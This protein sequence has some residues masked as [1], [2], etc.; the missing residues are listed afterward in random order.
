[1]RLVAL[2]LLIFCGV[3]A[4]VMLLMGIMIAEQTRGA[5]RIVL[6]GCMVLALLVPFS[7]AWAFR[8]GGLAPVGLVVLHLLAV[9]ALYV[10]LGLLV[11]QAEPAPTPRPP[12]GDARVV[13]EYLAANRDIETLDLSN[14]GLV[15]VPPAVFVLP[16]LRELRLN[17]NNLVTVPD[18][19]LDMPALRVV[20]LRDN[21][22]PVEEMARIGRAAQQAL[23]SGRRAEPLALVQ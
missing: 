18:A 4:M 22:I 9:P 6:Y 19:L 8:A 5:A 1:M 17:R 2:P 23:A 21:P 20:L 7:A 16:S 15:A 12:G 14:L 3:A 10:G 11:R 13:A